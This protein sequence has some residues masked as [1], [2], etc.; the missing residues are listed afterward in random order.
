MRRA[1]QLLLSLA[2]MLIMALFVGCQTAPGRTQTQNFDGCTFNIFTP[3]AASS[4]AV[5]PGP[6]VNAGDL[7]TQNMLVDT[8]GS[9][10]N[11][12]TSTPT[13][14]TPIEAHVNSAG[15]G[16]GIASKAASAAMNKLGLG[17]ANAAKTANAEAAA[18]TT[19]TAT[20]GTCADG[21]CTLK[22]TT[23]K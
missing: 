15:G 22:T 2:A 14:T 12:P 6:G 21:S 4:N 8:S 23:A 16:S 5:A 7:F 18:S 11:S 10:V 1:A 17:D 13:I 9:E 3:A 19:N 20:G